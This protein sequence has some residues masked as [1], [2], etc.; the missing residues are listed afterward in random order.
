MCSVL[1]FTSKEKELP[2]GGFNKLVSGAKALTYFTFVFNLPLN[3]GFFFVCSFS[4]PTWVELNHGV[5]I[6]ISCSS[7][8]REMGVTVS[9]VKSI[10]L[11]A[12]NED[13]LKVMTS[14]VTSL[15][16][17]RT[18]YWHGLVGDMNSLWLEMSKSLIE[19]DR[20]SGIKFCKMI[21]L[22]FASF[23]VS[24]LMLFIS[25]PPPLSLSFTHT[26]THTHTHSL[27]LSLSLPL[28]LSLSLYLY[29]SPSLSLYLYLS[30]S[31]TLSLSLSLSLSPSFT[32][33]LSLS[34]SLCLSLSLLRSVFTKET[35]KPTLNWKVSDRS[36]FLDQNLTSE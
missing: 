34:L 7:V 24:L 27:S 8:H 12:F 28:S 22:R 9:R 26:H 19:S 30:L 4:G 1:N 36:A 17:P 15:G 2:R 31:L 11:D 25:L 13:M 29:L 10:Q 32:L 5:F 23:P 14:L 20:K 16:K 18:M 33:S 6:C 35:S 21:L 3:F